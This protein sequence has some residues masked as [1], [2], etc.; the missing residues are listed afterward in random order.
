MVKTINEVVMNSE[1]KVKDEIK[2][3]KIYKLYFTLL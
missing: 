2:R 3:L 1:K